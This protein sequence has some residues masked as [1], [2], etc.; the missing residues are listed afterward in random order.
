MYAASMPT[1]W[2]QATMKCRCVIALAGI[3]ALLVGCGREQPK[4]A[5]FLPEW[6]LEI[7]QPIGQIEEILEEAE[8]QQLI[9]YTSANLGFLYDVK[10]YILFHQHI[11]SLPVTEQASRISEQRKWL[12]QRKTQ[13]DKANMEY[14]GGTF[15]SYAGNNAWMELTKKRIA[16]IEAMTD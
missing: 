2:K 10:L 5:G 1:G 6:K 15:A 13:V 8:Q 12:K 16:E 14:E 11:A 4:T 3:G 7:D 9:N